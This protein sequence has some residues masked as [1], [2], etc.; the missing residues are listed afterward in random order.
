[1][2]NREPMG[3]KRT[4]TAQLDI[5]IPTGFSAQ[6]RADG[7]EAQV[8]TWNA[9]STWRF[10]AQPRADGDEA[11][12]TTIEIG[13]CPRSFS[14]QP[15]AD[16]DEAA[17]YHGTDASSFSVSVLN[18]EPM[19]MKLP[20]RPL[21]QHRRNPVSVLN[22]EPMGMKLGIVIKLIECHHCFSAQ[23]RA[24]GDEA[25]D[26]QLGSWAINQRFSAQPRA[27]GDEAAG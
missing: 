11:V 12:G 18:R 7:D 6:P 10:S 8:I 23:P 25:W 22:R 9:A 2:L 26:V 1:M 5:T 16:G 4:L 3:M 19:G 20:H 15:R 17:L 13:S 21:P 14:A 24:D 27:D